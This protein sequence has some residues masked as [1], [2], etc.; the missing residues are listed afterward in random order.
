MY[1]CVLRLHHQF[2]F[3]YFNLSFK[4]TM[5][6]YVPIM[7]KLHS[8]I[9]GTSIV[10]TIGLCIWTYPALAQDASSAMSESILHTLYEEN[11]KNPE[12]TYIQKRIQEERVAIRGSIEA[13]LQKTVE[14][15]PEEQEINATN[16]PKALERQKTIVTVLQ[17]R[18]QERKIDLELLV[19]EEGAFYLQPTGQT[20]ALLPA[21]RLT[22]TH[23]EL[24]TKKAILEERVS[25]LESFLSQ[26]QQRLDKLETEQ[27]LLQFAL[28][29][30][31]GKYLLI[32]FCIWFIERTIRNTLLR[33]IH[34]PDRRYTVTKLISSITYILTAIW[35][36]ATVFAKYPSLV[37]SL[38]IVGAGLAIAFQDI[39]KDILGWALILQHRLFSTGDRITIGTYTGEVVDIGVLRTR[40]LEVGLPPHGVLEHTGKILSVPNALVLTLPI[41]NHSATSDFVNAEMHIT[42]TYESNWKKAHTLLHEIVTIETGAYTEHE[43]TQQR[44][45]TR[46]M[47]IH[48]QISGPEVYMDLAADGVEFIL[49]FSVP[50]GER[51]I[52]VST[53]SKKILE[54]FEQ[55]GDIALAYKTVRSIPDKKNT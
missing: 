20:G 55:E 39:V 12:S 43:R 53:L 46:M 40:V 44:E 7:R 18:L 13:E 17:E 16:V 52:I 41:T 2:V 49:R 50:I 6:R 19:A 35:I 34:N 29:I 51:R 15:P 25:L 11:L 37:T 32:L 9:F 26:Q 31:I 54:R 28:F 21:Y 48:R 4:I 24:L 3:D 8:S 33:R 38:A 42:V 10:V 23:A 14:V 30:S 47:Y 1:V 27:L 22:T 5:I 45:R 36:V